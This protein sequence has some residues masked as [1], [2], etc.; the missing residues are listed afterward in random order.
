MVNWE[1]IGAI[2]ELLGSLAVVATLVFLIKQIR[3]NTTMVQNNTAQGASEAIAAWS[4]QL[5]DNPDLYRIFREGLVDDNQLS[6]E[7]RG[8]FDLIMFQAFHANSTAYFQYKSG[9]FNTDR[10]EAEMLI[11]SENH[12]TPGGRASWERQ[13]HM[14]DKDFRDEIENRFNRIQDD[15]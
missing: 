12:D 3:S 14:L 2:A 1:A 11:F 9:G 6:K 4:R 10:F 13:K 7:D 5:T 8:L 15:A